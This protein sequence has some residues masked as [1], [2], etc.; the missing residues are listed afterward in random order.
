[1]DHI[2]KKQVCALAYTVSPV[3]LW[4]SLIN[5]DDIWTATEILQFKYE[6]I[7]FKM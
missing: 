4:I 7:V 5:V 3:E 6:G 2:S 1:M